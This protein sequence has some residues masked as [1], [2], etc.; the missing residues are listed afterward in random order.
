ML[1]LPDFTGV[2]EIGYR[3]VEVVAVIR[4]GSALRCGAF[5]GPGPLHPYRLMFGADY[6]LMFGADKASQNVGDY[7]G[8]TQGN[9]EYGD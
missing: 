5:K 6:R 8:T 4:L 3:C 2:A 1:R 7:V 9:Q